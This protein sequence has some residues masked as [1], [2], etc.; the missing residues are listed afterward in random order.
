MRAI[1]RSASRSGRSSRRL[2]QSRWKRYEPSEGDLVVLIGGRTGRDGCGG[3]TGSS[4]AHDETSIEQCGAEVQKGNPLTERKLQR[5]FRNGAFSK[6]VKRCNDFGAGGVCVAIGEL[7]DGLDIDLDAVPKKY[8]GLDGTELA[9]SESQERMA[10]VIRPQDADA[11]LK[12]AEDENLEATIVA[13]VTDEGRMRLM[14]N[15]KTIVD[16]TRD[17]L[18]SNGATQ[19]AAAR[20][21]QAGAENLFAEKTEDTA[22]KTLLSLLADLN[23]CSQ[24]GL[25]EMFD[26]S[27]GAGS[28]TMPLGGKN[29]MTPVQ[30]MCAKIPVQDTDSKTATLMS[31]GMDPYLMEKSPFLGAVYAIL[32]SEAKLVAAGG[33]VGDSWLT[34]QEYFERMTGEPERWGKPLAALLGAY[35]AQKELGVAAIG[36]KDSMSGTFRDIDVPPT[37]CSFCVAPVL[38]ANVITPEFK[39]AGSKLYLLDI[40]RDQDGLP[41]FEDAKRKYGRL[42]KMIEDRAVLSAYAV[43]RGGMLA[44]A[45][46]CA[47]GNGLGVKLFPQELSGL[48]CKAYGAVLVE[49]A[50]IADADFTLVGEI[51]EEPFIEALGESIPAL[52][53]ARGLYRHARAGIPHQNGGQRPGGYAPSV[54]KRISLSANI[55]RRSRAS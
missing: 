38:A 2:R 1:R 23:I 53:C 22:E 45:A 46:K 11:V 9:I 54:R 47:F 24:K 26:G 42:H 52:P 29:Q 55:K 37:L 31:Y 21:E 7:A 33:A 41:D 4:K 3:A 19:H 48:T 17:F 12:M 5:L 14:W 6:L 40:V 28:V 49:A 39:K 32:L 15:G 50:D 8:E 30:A 44:G 43:E 36:G 20:V 27:I 51:R 10:V 16:I 25:V 18:N 13:R 35:H 34:L